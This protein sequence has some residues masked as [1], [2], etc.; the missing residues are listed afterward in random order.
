[1]GCKIIVLLCILLFIGILLKKKENFKSGNNYNFVKE[2]SFKIG[3]NSFNNERGNDMYSYLS[4][5]DAEKLIKNYNFDKKIVKT[6]FDKIDNNKTIKLFVLGFDKKIQK[7]YYQHEPEKLYGFKLQTNKE[8]ETCTY[9]SRTNNLKESLK[10]FLKDEDIDFFI[11]NFNIQEN[12]FYYENK[13]YYDGGEFIK[14]FPI[15][16][17]ENNIKLNSFEFQKFIDYFGLYNKKPLKDFIKEKG[18]LI[19]AGISVNYDGTFNLYLN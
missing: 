17:N 18:N 4:K 16:L 7:I 5:S 9:F 11:K 19:I 8:I 13:T 14:G 12:N 2:Y 6:V 15:Q 3:K 1:M 10:E